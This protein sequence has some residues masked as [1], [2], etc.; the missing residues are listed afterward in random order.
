MT[1]VTPTTEW[2]GGARGIES[3]E[4]FTR[5]RERNV[6]QP[7][8]VACPARSALAEGRFHI[9]KIGTCISPTIFA[10]LAPER[11]PLSGMAVG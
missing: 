4:V 2:F 1:K 10:G 6:H 9:G 7:G 8:F 3:T 5:S 11:Q